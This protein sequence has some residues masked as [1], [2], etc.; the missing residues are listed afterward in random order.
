MAPVA[1]VRRTAR[2]LPV[3]LVVMLLVLPSLVVVP[4]SFSSGQILEFPPQGFSLRWYQAIA[5]NEVWIEAARNSLAVALAVVVLST[6]IGAPAGIALGLWRWRGRSLFL[7]FALVPAVMPPMVLALG[8]YITYARFDLIGYWGLVAAHTVMAL[9]FVVLTVMS[10]AQLVDPTL[11]TAAQSLGAPRWRVLVEIVL[12]L[13]KGGLAAGAIFAFITSWDEVV[14]AIY[15][16]DPTF[17]TLPVVMWNQL[18]ERVDPNVAVVATLLF[19]V[20]SL[21]MAY[22][23]LKGERK[24]RVQ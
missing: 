3:A 6:L 9:P 12:P 5:S 1:A 18:R 15:L 24:Q 23:V 13:V 19:A 11:L 16:T 17:K 7:G 21:V 14:V 8:M 10:S 4:M 20:T 22:V 2:A